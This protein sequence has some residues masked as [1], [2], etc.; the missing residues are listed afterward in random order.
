MLDSANTA[1]IGKTATTNWERYSNP[2]T[3]KLFSQ[4]AATTNT[5]LQHQIVNQ[6]EK[7]MLSDVPVIPM[8]ED[9][10][11]YQYSTSGFSGWVTQKNPYAL[12][13]PYLVPD[14]EQLLLHLV[15]KG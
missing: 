9:V 2:A 10:A 6:L 7:V 12:P 4:Y 8:T 5:A 14:N 13:S 11:W 1:P 3:D 15:P